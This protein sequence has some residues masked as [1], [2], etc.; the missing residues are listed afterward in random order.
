MRLQHRLQ[1]TAAVRQVVLG[2]QGVRAVDAAL[3]EAVRFEPLEALGEHARGHAGR[4]LEELLE[5]AAAEEEVAE[6][7]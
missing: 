1:R 7:E 2:A 5:L 4:E 3:D 6:D